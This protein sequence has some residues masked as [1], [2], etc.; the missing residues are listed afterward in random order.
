M[1]NYP[2]KNPKA[3][4]FIP[5]VNKHLTQ[6]NAEILHKDDRDI[7]QKRRNYAPYD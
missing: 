4:D 3:I 2:G 6:L 5:I 7:V 1:I